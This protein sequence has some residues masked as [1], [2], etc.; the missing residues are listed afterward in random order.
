MEKKRDAMEKRISALEEK[1]GK[2]DEFRKRLIWTI[3][4]LVALA[5]IVE[6]F[7]RLYKVAGK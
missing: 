5:T 6:Y 7:V 4:I 3:G 1:Q 2:F